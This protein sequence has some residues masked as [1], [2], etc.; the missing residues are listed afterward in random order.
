VPVA[1]N[2]VIKEGPSS[3]SAVVETAQIGAN[4]KVGISPFGAW[5]LGV[6]SIIGSMAWLIHGPMIAKA[7]PLA[8]LTAWGL[9]CLMT[10]PL[11]LI[12]AE[13]SSMFPA[14]GGP[15]VY[16]YYAFKR[17]I[18]GAGE[19]IGFLTGW[20]FW[21]AMLT[22]L[23]CMS[24][25]LADLLTSAYWGNPSGAPL[26]FGPVVIVGLFATTTVLN[27][28]NVGQATTLNNVITLIKL[29]AAVAFGALVFQAPSTSLANLMHAQAPS[30][31]ADF[32]S[33][34]A[35]VLMLAVAGYGGVEL[36]GCTSSETANAQK[37]VPR[38]ILSTLFAVG[39]IYMAMCFCVSVASPY[40]LSADKTTMVIAGTGV[41]A[42]CAALAGFL[43][44]KLAGTLMFAAVVVSIVGCSF[45]CLLTCAR[46]GFSMAK[47]GLFPA[48]FGRLN[49][50]TKV[51][52]YTL[53]F[54]FWC[55]CGI[56]V[57]ANLLA[58]TGYC[59]DAYSFLCEV[60]GFI[61]AFAAMLYGF[62]LIGLR[63]TDPEM[64]RP[65]RLGSKGNAVAWLMTVFTTLVY[66]FAAFICA[67][68]MHQLTGILLLAAGVPIYWWYRSQV[69]Q[70]KQ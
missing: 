23:S 58:R 1:S 50:R 10:L 41:Q 2:E 43:G 51:P 19:M 36:A 42:N 22:G 38:A 14:A 24:N 63:Y 11:A 15:Y 60:F 59:P 27:L 61:Y 40:V 5:M 16:K 4:M 54:Q 3:K 44:G 64:P 7:G 69:D 34:V 20:L 30:G 26:W 68:R 62:C 70:A 28:M 47:T 66:G 9:S 37:T 13:L 29:F 55:L 32:W 52:S 57:G 25:G 39:I 53:W 6:G 21:I 46:V 49:E 8:A 17:M 56:G 33:N 31:D 45:T 18:P 48:Q 35:G 67:G 65:F 12:L